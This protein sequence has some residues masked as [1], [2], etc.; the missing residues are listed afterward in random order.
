MQKASI[1][2]SSES[3]TAKRQRLGSAVRRVL[4]VVALAR[5]AQFIETIL[6]PLVAFRH[7]AG[8]A[9][10]AAVLLA[11]S[12]GSTGGSLLGGGAVDRIGTRRKGPA[13]SAGG[14]TS[15]RF[16]VSASGYR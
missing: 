12:V 1:D 4:A 8:T 7:G 3:A 5:A 15:S 14:Q 6:F 2:R 16:G 9:A 11:M 13:L 10:A